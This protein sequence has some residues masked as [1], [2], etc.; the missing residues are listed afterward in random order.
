MIFLY[1]FLSS[2]FGRR[3]QNANMWTS[4]SFIWASGLVVSSL[5]LL[6]CVSFSGCCCRSVLSLVL[7][8]WVYLL[9][10]WCDVFFWCSSLIATFLGFMHFGVLLFSCS[11]VVFL[12]L[13]ALRQVVPNGALQSSCL[14]FGEVCVCCPETTKMR[15]QCSLVIQIFGEKQAFWGAPSN[16]WLHHNARP[17]RAQTPSLPGQMGFVTKPHSNLEQ[18]RPILVP[19]NSQQRPLTWTHQHRTFH[20]ECY[21]T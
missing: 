1:F 6:C 5:M 21:F 9:L 10:C 15:F 3:G 14:F 8:W 18:Q 19:K 12:A 17:K 20:S 13:S 11:L 2:Y 16:G 7:C 4:S